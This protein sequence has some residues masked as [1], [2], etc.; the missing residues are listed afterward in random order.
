M[1]ADAVRRARAAHR[2]AHRRVGGGP[3]PAARGIRRRRRDHRTRRPQPGRRVG[4]RARAP[5]DRRADAQPAARRHRVGA[6]DAARAH[7]RGGRRGARALR[8]GDAGAHPQ[9]A[10]RPVPARPLV[11]RV[12]R[13]GRRDRARRRP[14]AARRG[15]RRR[16]RRP[17]RDARPRERGRRAS[18]RRAPCS[19]DSPS[20]RCSARSRASSSS[21]AR[22]A[23]ATARSSTGCSARSRAPTGRR[24]RSPAGRW[25]SSACRCSRARRTLDAFAFGD[26]A[27]AALGVH[28]GRSRALLLVATALLTGALVAVSGAIGFVGLILPHAR[29]AARRLAAPG[30]A[31]PVGARRRDLPGVGR[32]RRAHAVRPARAARRHRHGAHRRAGV[33]GAHAADRR[34]A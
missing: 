30:A 13:R 15:V 29:A 12:G 20:R 10:R 17:R 24:S 4:E 1:R 14:A 9:P 32:H 6:A 7:R 19:R 23:T 22:R 18:P 25:S 8:R 26:T 16:P 3:R 5:R 27:A 31:A 21:G 11:G 28:V 34:L 33:R 2:P